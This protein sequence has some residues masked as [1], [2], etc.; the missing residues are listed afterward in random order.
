MI[1]NLAAL[2]ANFAAKQQPRLS[3]QFDDGDPR[4][5]NH[6][7]LEQQK[8]RAKELLREW[9]ESPPDGLV[10]PKLSVAQ[11]HIARSYGFKSWAQL[12]FYIEQT[13]IAL[14]AVKSGSPNS[15]DEDHRALHIRCGNDIE[16]TLAVA[17]FS[18][19]FLL[20]IDPFAHGPVPV[21]ATLEEYLRIRARYI[22]GALKPGYDE[23][24]SQL[25]Q[26]YG[27]LD[28]AH[29]YDAVYL[30]HEHDTYDQLLVAK[31]LDYFSDP[32]KR[33]PV[34][35]MINVTHFPGVKIFNGIG[36]LPPEAMRVLWHEFE[37]VTP[38]QYEI[39]QQTWAAVRSPTPAAL[40]Q[41]VAT[42]TP[43]L[44]TMAIAMDRFLKELPSKR[45]GL[46]LTENLTLQ[47]LH[48]KG[49]MNAARLFGWHVNHYEPLPFMGDMPYWRL[50]KELV[51]VKHPAIRME[52]RGDK[53]NEWQISMTDNGNQLF[54]NEADWLELNEIDRWV[55]GIHVN[56][57]EGQIFR[58]DDRFIGGR[59][60]T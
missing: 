60:A 59:Y 28:R 48:D 3:G 32:A 45:N 41:I 16:N 12:K 4:K 13:H 29:D 27:H 54:C 24:I 2:R 7:S 51:E 39:G 33:P 21:T 56:S 55:G 20:F 37:A 17:G 31:L 35:K 49:P 18:G 43:E 34:V 44:P 42:G 19:D 52:K 6:L 22:S 9:R 50:L 26:S 25:T 14:T 40:Q 53:P 5:L 38:A 46:N 57:K 11:Y 10:Q 47:I 23:A 15:L 1:N 58:V 8:K 36:Q 30:W